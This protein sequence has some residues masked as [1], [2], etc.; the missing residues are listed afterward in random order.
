MAFVTNERDLYLRGEPLYPSNPSECVLH[1]CRS[2]E[3]SCWSPTLGGGGGGG[4]GGGK[5][6]GDASGNRKQLSK[7]C[8]LTFCLTSL[9]LFVDGTS[10]LYCAYTLYIYGYSVVAIIHINIILL[11]C[12]V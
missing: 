6:A 11:H 3:A 7:H 8:I 4:G 5:G 12:M 9:R 2:Q 10:F 1:T